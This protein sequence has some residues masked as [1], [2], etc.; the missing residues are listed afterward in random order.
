MSEDKS[1]FNEY[2]ETKV[3]CMIDENQL[4]LN[5]LH[6]LEYALEEMTRDKKMTPRAWQRAIKGFHQER[7]K[8]VAGQGVKYQH[9]IEEAV[10]KNLRNQVA[11]VFQMAAKN[12]EMMTLA[13]KE[14]AGL[15]G[16]AEDRQRAAVESQDQGEFKFESVEATDVQK[17]DK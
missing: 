8:Q 16:I 2:A 15:R 14:L 4:I 9:A 13:T 11:I 3:K 7:K 6:V 10:A 12:E 5:R 1:L 17:G